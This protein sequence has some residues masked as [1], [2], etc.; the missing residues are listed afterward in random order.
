MATLAVN[1]VAVRAATL[2]FQQNASQAEV[3]KS[4]QEVERLRGERERKEAWKCAIRDV[5]DFLTTPEW[6]AV[7][8]M[9]AAAKRS[10]LLA[11]G[12]FGHSGTLSLGVNGF[13]VADDGRD[14]EGVSVEY[15][16]NYYLSVREEHAAAGFLPTIIEHIN[17]FAARAEAVR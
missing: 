15:A 2:R 13:V 11:G 3:T 17:C 8:A 6:L 5:E 1:V 9:L 16:I 4:Q 14:R 7:K 12:Y 10:L